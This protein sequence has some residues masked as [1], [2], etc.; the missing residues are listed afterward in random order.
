MPVPPFPSCHQP[1]RT[2]HPVTT[3]SDLTVPGLPLRIRI[4]KRGCLLNKT[5]E[6]IPVAVHEDCHVTIKDFYSGK[7]RYGK[8]VA[9]LR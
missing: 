8:A 6:G 7:T 2:W 4:R 3:T 9:C 5:Y 1:A